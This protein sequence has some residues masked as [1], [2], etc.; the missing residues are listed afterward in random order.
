MTFYAPFNE[1]D[2]EF[3]GSDLACLGDISGDGIDDLWVGQRYLNYIYYGGQPFDTIPD[4]II[5]WQ[6]VGPGRVCN[7]G[8]INND[9]YDD[10]S[11][12]DDSYLRSYVSFIYC[13]PGM[14]T[15]VDVAFSDYDFQVAISQGPISHVGIDISPGGD[16]DGDGIDD[17]LI[18]MRASNSD[19]L[20]E[21]WL[22]ILAGWDEPVA[23]NENETN[24]FPSIL[25]LY[26][27]YPNPF[28]SGT[29]IEFNLPRAGFTELK[30]FNLLGQIVASPLSDHLPAGNHCIVWDG[31][32][33]VGQ[34]T[35]T[36]I[37]FYQIT[38]G[39]FSQ[40]RKMILLK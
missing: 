26:Q 29:I 12:V 13:Y 14:D 27:N 34:S 18:S 38:S 32:D 7:V 36:G 15:L 1:R 5:E 22:V 21:G 23:V 3:F 35:A 4:K 30:I 39:D 8:D 33:K 10:V 20:D 40:T 2:Y 28:N 31:L 37:Y 24:L 17:V 11:L 25:E 19:G 16:I 9:G 6:Y